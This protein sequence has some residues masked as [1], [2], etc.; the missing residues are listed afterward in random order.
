MGRQS[1]A[2]RLNHCR[3][4]AGARSRWNEAIP[5]PP[6]NTSRAEGFS[7]RRLGSCIGAAGNSSRGRRSWAGSMGKRA[8]GMK[9]SIEVLRKSY[10]TS[11][12][13]EILPFTVEAGQVMMLRRREDGETQSWL[14]LH[15]A[16]MHPN[17]TVLEHLELYLGDLFEPRASI[18]HS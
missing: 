4:H 18:V 13:Y 12:W 3:N 8:Y 1:A 2:I 17:D 14:V 16:G 10:M 9:E 11:I 5:A 6:G 15:Q 7:G